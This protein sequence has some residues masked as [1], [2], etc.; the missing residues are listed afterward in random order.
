MV[1]S[2]APLWPVR[3]WWGHQ[4][5]TTATWS[6][7]FRN[8]ISSW[9][10]WFF[11]YLWRC[12][13]GVQRSEGVRRGWGGVTPYRDSPLL[14]PHRSHQWCLWDQWVRQ[15]MPRHC[16]Y[17][18][19]SG[20]QC[21]M[22]VD[23]SSSSSSS[24]SIVFTNCTLTWFVSII[25]GS[26]EQ[27]VLPRFW[28][29]TGPKFLRTSPLYGPSLWTFMLQTFYRHVGRLQRQHV[30]TFSTVIYCSGDYS[31]ERGQMTGFNEAPQLLNLKLWVRGRHTNTN[32]NTNK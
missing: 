19:V 9:R 30:S 1:S 27:L 16:S 23:V 15:E 10:L 3:Q 6:F 7:T 28:V 12:Y 11:C 22:G 2:S 32:T 5:I 18:T 13:R 8:W 17:L 31:S 4:V 24:P 14:T 29:R 21:I 25:R 20:E 26:K